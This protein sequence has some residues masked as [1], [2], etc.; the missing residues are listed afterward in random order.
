MVRK[1]TGN[2]DRVDWEIPKLLND[3]YVNCGTLITKGWVFGGNQ[4]YKISIGY[5]FGPDI[6]YSANDES[7]D[8]FT[9]HQ[10]SE[11]PDWMKAGDLINEFEKKHRDQQTPDVVIS[12]EI[13]TELGKDNGC[14]RKCYAKGWV[15]KKAYISE[16]GVSVSAFIPPNPTS[17]RDGLFYIPITKINEIEGFA[18]CSFFGFDT[19]NLSTTPACVLENNPDTYL[20]Y[21][22]E[23]ELVRIW[24]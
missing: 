10:V 2:F 19:P 16:L 1:E 12:E 13:R 6:I 18:V 21:L 9:I 4:K 24:Y 23:R 3:G 11:K 8:F 22:I 17:S 14:H 15:E 7:D 20:V 5:V